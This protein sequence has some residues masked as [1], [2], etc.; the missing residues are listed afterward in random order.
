M[1]SE[2]SFK[3]FGPDN[4][5]LV[6]DDPY[7]ARRRRTRPCARGRIRACTRRRRARATHLASLEQG[8]VD[9]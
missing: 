7:K 3:P 6:D 5:V 9:S 1:W 2:D 8:L 4:T